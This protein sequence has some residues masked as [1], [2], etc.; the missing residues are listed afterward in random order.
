MLTFG[1]TKVINKELQGA[2]EPIEIQDVNADNIVVSKL[3]KTK[4]NSKYSISYLHDV[5]R[6]FILILPKMRGYVKNFKAKDGYK[7]NKLI[8][9]RKNDEKL[10]QKYKI[11]WT[12]IE[13]FLRY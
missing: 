10:L 13:D 3:I 8:S 5:I 12:K 2:K 7:D 1:E 11:I 9:F 4:T 6:P